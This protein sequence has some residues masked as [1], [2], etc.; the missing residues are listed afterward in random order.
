MSTDTTALLI[1]ILLMVLIA[2]WVPFLDTCAG[3]LQRRKQRRTFA[4]SA[5]ASPARESTAEL[6]FAFEKTELN[7]I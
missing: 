4:R 3:C 7:L 5:D 1:S 6:P 2:A